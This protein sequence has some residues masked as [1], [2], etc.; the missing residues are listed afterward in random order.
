MKSLLQYD[1]PGNIRELENCVARAVT[2]GL[3]DFA[4]AAGGPLADGDGSC[5]AWSPVEGVIPNSFG[6]P[7][8]T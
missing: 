6:I 4:D 3:E 8:P 1:W 5:H 2:L 7:H